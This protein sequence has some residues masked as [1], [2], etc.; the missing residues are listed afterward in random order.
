MYII[1]G[2]CIYIYIYMYKY[3]SCHSQ[4]RGPSQI[5]QNVE[6]QGG[7]LALQGSADDSRWQLAK[8][9]V[10]KQ[11]ANSS[12]VVDMMINVYE[13]YSGLVKECLGDSP[14]FHSALDVACRIFVNALPRASEWL[15]RY[16]HH[17]LDK[18]FKESRLSEDARN[19]ALDHVGFL[20]GC[21]CYF[22]Y[23][24]GIR[25]RI[26]SKIDFHTHIICCYYFIPV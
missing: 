10:K 20:F 3:T 19:D 26:L 25:A 21:V 17:L 11:G 12:D 15:A 9:G 6:V 5:V 4:L 23:H 18:D 8:R 24:S 14:A 16:A 1:T 2:F 13:H 7:L 22:T